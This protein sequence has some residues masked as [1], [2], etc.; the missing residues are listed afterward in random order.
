MR[1]GIALLGAASMIVSVAGGGGA[2]LLRVSTMATG[3]ETR[4]AAHQGTARSFGMLP[5]SFERNAGQFD[6]RVRFLSQGPGY[7]VFLTS[8]G[9]AVLSLP[10]ASGRHGARGETAFGMSHGRAQ[11]DVLSMDLIGAARPASVVGTARLGGTVNRFTGNDPRAWWTGIPTY[12]GVLYRG[13]YPGID[14]RYYGNQSGN[15]EYD[16]NI[17]AGA[18]ASAVAIAFNGE[19]ALSLET[20][21]ALVLRMPGGDIRQPV[22]VAYQVVGGVRRPVAVSYVIRGS[23][24]GFAVGPHVA[25]A[26]LVIDP[27]IS[28]STYIGGS[29]FDEVD[30]VAVDGHGNAYLFGDTYSMDLPLGNC[31]LQCGPVG[32][33]DDFVAKMNRRGTALM[34]LTYLGGTADDEGF[35]MTIDRAGNAYVTGPTLST[36]FPT[37]PGAYQTKAPGGDHDGFVTKI[38]P[39]GDLVFSTYLGGSGHDAALTP[40]VNG[41]GD[42]Y[43]I[44][45]T[46]STDLPADG[47]QKT[48]LG[49]DCTIFNEFD[50]GDCDEGGGL[51]IFVAELNPAGSAL[52]HLTYL[53]GTTGDEVGV[54]L[55]LDRSGNA[56]VSTETSSS[57]YPVTQGAYQTSFAGGD[58]TDGVNSDAA[59]SKLDPAL[60][61]LVYS[62]YVGGTGDDCF[63]FQCFVAVD[64]HG[65]AFLASNTDSLDFPFT[66][67]AFQTSNAGGFDDAVTKLN[68]EGTGLV[69]STYIGGSGDDSTVNDRTIAVRQ[70]GEAYI[71][72]YTYS[73][74]FPTVNPVQASY[75]G[76]ADATLSVLSRGGT[77]LVFSTYVG[78]NDDDLADMNIDRSGAAYLAG[79]TCSR[80]YPVT[81]HAFQGQLAGVCD[82]MVTKILIH[83]GALAGAVHRGPA[84][85]S[86]PRGSRVP[87][88]QGLTHIA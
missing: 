88:L 64:G 20:S 26:P 75:Q 9:G 6:P 40:A 21:G 77:A 46:N 83:G 76:A 80:N 37:T 53:G 78:G 74:D 29:D 81:R 17:A 72:G 82:G 71:S 30:A 24:V 68:A 33:H 3:Q 65:H 62:T 12:A 10:R 84:V 14:L 34:W 87:R 55:A 58:G 63:F 57:D 25:T 56:Y 61:T 31:S 2:G 23:T 52:L 16:V 4:A 8:R 28:Y 13:L 1:R 5:L 22:P 85:G 38:G 41:A 60:S 45:D 42:V 59:V 73:S 48:N 15:L 67:G 51:D 49:G 11:S 39:S 7:T 44:G 79:V 54:G 86:G 66:P 19:V 50:P 32:G 36:D 70:N 69:Y 27:K 43:V 18:D 47:Y 35:G